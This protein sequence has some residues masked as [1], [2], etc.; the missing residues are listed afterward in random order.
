MLKIKILL[1]TS[2]D[3]WPTIM[4]DFPDIFLVNSH[5]KRDCGNNNLKMSNITLLIFHKLFRQN[6]VGT[7]EWIIE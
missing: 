3:L 2:R 5:S 1:R 7:A 4:D 6:E